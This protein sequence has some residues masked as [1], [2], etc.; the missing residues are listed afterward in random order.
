MKAENLSTQLHHEVLAPALEPFGNADEITGANQREPSRGTAAAPEDAHIVDSEHA[1]PCVTEVITRDQESMDKKRDVP[2]FEPQP[3]VNTKGME[4]SASAPTRPRTTMRKSSVPV[5]M[6]HDMRKDSLRGSI[7]E[8]ALHPRQYNRR[9]GSTRKDIAP[10]VLQ[11]TNNGGGDTSDG[12][13]IPRGQDTDDPDMIEGTVPK[14]EEDP[15]AIYRTRT[16]TTAPFDGHR[17]LHQTREERRAEKKEIKARKRQKLVKDPITGKEIWIENARG[18]AKKTIANE[19]LVAPTF[20][21]LHKSELSAAQLLTQLHK[22]PLK[23]DKTNVL[24]YPMNPPEWKELLEESQRAL[25]QWGYIIIAVLITVQLLLSAFPIRYTLWINIIVAVGSIIFVKNRVEQSFRESFQRAEQVRGENATL[26]ALPESVEWL[27]NLI[28]TIWPTINPEF[29]AGPA[30]LLEDVLQRQVP[31]LVNTVKVTDLDI[32]SVPL[33]L[34]SMRYL[35]DDGVPRGD[36]DAAGEYVNLEVTFGYRAG[37]IDKSLKSRAKNIHMLIWFMVGLKKVLGIPIPIWVEILGIVGRARVRIQLLPDPPFLKNG[38]ISLLGMPKVELSTTPI[39]THLFNVMNLPFVSQIVA[40]AVKT[41]C[42]DII[43]PR[44]YTLDVSKLMVGD[45]VKKETASIGIIMISLHGATNVPRADHRPGRSKVDPYL[46]VQYSRFGKTMYSTRVISQDYNPVW[47]ESCFIPILPGVVKAGEKLRIN[48]WDSDRFTADDLLGRVEVD[49]TSMVV[50]AGQFERRIDRVVGTKA[51]LQWSVGFFSKKDLPDQPVPELCDSSV[52]PS[53][54]NDPAFKPD[55]P[56]VSVDTKTEQLICR[57]PPN[58]DYPGIVSIQ[59]HQINDLGIV[60]PKKKQHQRNGRALQDEAVELGQGDDSGS[61]PSSYCSVALNDELIYK[62]RTR[63]YTSR[64]IFN[65]SFERFVRSL[66]DTRIRFTVRDQRFREEDPIVGIL[67][68]DLNEELKEQGQVTRW[69]PLSEGIG[70]GFIRISLLFRNIDCKLPRTLQGWNVGTLFIYGC[71]AVV[72]KADAEALRDCSLRIDAMLGHKTIGAFHAALEEDGSVSWDLGDT[73]VM[74]VRRRHASSLSFECHRGGVPF[75]KKGLFSG[76]YG[77]SIIALSALDD[78]QRAKIQIP[79][80]QS[81][82]YV[83]FKQ[84]SLAQSGQDVDRSLIKLGFLEVDCCLE[85]GLS[86]AHRKFSKRSTDLAQT[87]DAWETEQAYRRRLAFDALKDQ[88]EAQLKAARSND[89]TS[90][91]STEYKIKTRERRPSQITFAPPATEDSEEETVN[92]NDED[93]DQFAEALNDG[94][95]ADWND[96][97]SSINSHK[98]GKRSISEWYQDKQRDRREMHRRHRG[99]MQRKPARTAVWM[100]NSM[101]LGISK[102]SRALSINRED[103]LVEH[104]V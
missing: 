65:A 58:K 33:R 52:P 56:K 66:R 76:I 1:T 87:H 54:R 45:D 59:I 10:D 77:A 94:S 53:L 22:I 8:E 48:L 41:V 40:F 3:A 30:D 50:N 6:R 73:I 64:P 2:T 72:E 39:T 21:A 32:G 5:N 96:D 19:G 49:V 28:R 103:N 25:F 93:R 61:A 98:S 102:V 91:A 85:A 82:D 71:R 88:K 95:E 79:I 75:T 97:A 47:E 14:D 84:N 12:Y 62:T 51:H 4:S 74:P 44:S 57:L 80:F 24:F 68:L 104:E 100:K 63:A 11:P 20:E 46:T 90:V 7:N 31:S 36:E 16:E 26:S 99:I 69:Y 78:N 70:Y 29:F 55:Q 9:Y 86:D 18:S 60:Q 35:P 34:L 42:K 81:T 27:N 101:R 92:L 13:K 38:T 67:A 23:D 83:R 17:S 89:Q 15:D 43:A 37:K